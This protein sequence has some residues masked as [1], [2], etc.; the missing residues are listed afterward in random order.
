MPTAAPSAA[1]RLAMAAPMLRE[2]P[3]T[4]ATLPASFLFSVLIMFFFWFWFGGAS[5]ITAGP[6]G[7]L[8]QIKQKHLRRLGCG[9]LQCAFITHGEG[10]AAGQFCAVDLHFAFGDVGPGVAGF[11][12]R[13]LHALAG[14]Q[15]GEQ[16]VGVL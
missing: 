5:R 7:Y 9:D 15:L 16:Q 4:R 13:M 14:F 12:E 8:V 11:R 10:I 2:A 3:V 6:A 1:S